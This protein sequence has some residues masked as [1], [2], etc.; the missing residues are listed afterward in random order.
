MKTRNGFVSN[1]SSTSFILAMEKEKPCACCGLS[2]HDIFQFLSKFKPKKAS[3]NWLSDPNDMSVE[4]YR[5]GLETELKTLEVGLRVML[6]KTTWATTMLSGDNEEVARAVDWV[7]RSHLQFTSN[8][9]S[10]ARHYGRRIVEKEEYTDEEDSY[11]ANLP[12]DADKDSDGNTSFDYMIQTLKDIEEPVIT[13][14]QDIK[15]LV[16]FS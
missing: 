15:N 5:A 4:N 7:K 14:I 10:L 6:D 2:T 13:R 11:F 3:S 12:E 1:S 8:S 9:V 16:L